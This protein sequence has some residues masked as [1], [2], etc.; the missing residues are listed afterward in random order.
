MPT[1]PQRQ[2]VARS[3]FTLVE[4][5]VVVAI[6]GILTAMLFPVFSRARERARQTSCTSNLRQLY[7]GYSMYAQEH[8]GR[9]PPYNNN[10]NSC[11]GGK[12][13]DKNR[14]KLP[15]QGQKLVQS[16]LP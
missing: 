16:L 5:L 8:D 9:I 11:I 13:P 6:I 3:G 7:L 10:A 14:Y 4:L 2:F 15:E 1:S 12:R